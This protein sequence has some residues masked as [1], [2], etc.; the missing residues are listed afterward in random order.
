[1]YG[2]NGDT[3]RKLYK[4]RLSGYMEWGGMSETRY[5]RTPY[6]CF[7]ENCGPNL[8]MDETALSKDELFTIV[9]NK[10][11]HGGPGTLVAMLYGTKVSEIVAVLEEAIPVWRRLKVKEVTCDLSSAMM[12][13]ARA[14]FPQAIITNDRF[15]V[16]Q[17]FN[18]AMDDLRIDIRHQVR[19]DE[20][21]VQEMC[22]EQGFEY[23]PIKARNG[24][25][26]PQILVRTKRA[27]MVS[28]EKWSATQRQR[29]EI[30]FENYPQIEQAYKVMQRLRKIFNQKAD[31]LK[32]GAMLMKWFKDVEALGREH[33]NTV[34]RTF[35]NNYKTIVNYFRS[36]ATNASAESFNA[37]IKM[38]R[39]QLRGVSDP[40]FFI[41]RLCKLFA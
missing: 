15:H 41:F 34:V 32:G 16:Q 2:V 39:T 37:K 10:D 30:L 5:S 18:E 20:A 36:R 38:F 26:W 21:T 22:K 17:L 3:L 31:Y 6:V 9:T 29:M 12:E 25:T 33:F 23:V 14:S 7:P 4:Y 13:S 28:K 19:K 8:S 27:L 40:L 24:E 11:A 35:K 1:M